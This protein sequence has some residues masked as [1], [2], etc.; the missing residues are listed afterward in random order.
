MAQRTAPTQNTITFVGPMMTSQDKQMPDNGLRFYAL[1]DD[2]SLRVHVGKNGQAEFTR[3]N[4]LVL[5]QDLAKQLSVQSGEYW[6]P[7]PDKAMPTRP[8]CQIRDPQRW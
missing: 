5:P 4:M 7:R 1:P 3:M 2:G 8:S 6:H